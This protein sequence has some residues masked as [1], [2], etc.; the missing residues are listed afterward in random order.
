MKRLSVLVAAAVVSGVALTAP[1]AASAPTTNLVPWVQA[2]D[3]P[4]GCTTTCTDAPPEGPGGELAYDAASH[5]M[6][7]F[8]SGGNSTWVWSG[9]AWSQVADAGDAGCTNDCTHSPPTRNT[10]GM[11]YD[12]VSKAVIVF[13]GNGLNDTWAWNGTSW[14]QIADTGDAGCTTGCSSS[15]PPTLGTQMAFD[16][17]TNQMVMFGGAEPNL[18]NDYNDTWILTYHGGTSYSWSQV[19]DNLDPGCTDTCIASPPTTNVATMTYDVASRQLIV[20]GGEET[21]EEANGQSD[22]WSWTGTTWQQL[23]DDNGNDAG[24]GESSPESLQCPSSPGPRVGAGMAYDPALGQVILFG[25]QT[26]YSSVEYNDTWAWNGTTWTH[27][28][29]AGDPSCVTSCTHSPPPSDT[30]AM[31]DD[32]GSNQL[33]VFGAALYGEG[34]DTWVARAVP[35][36]PSA[37]TKVHATSSKTT[38]TVTWSAP[39][40]L[41]ATPVSKYTVTLTPG[42]KNCTTTGATHCSI[43]G[44][45][46]KDHYTVAV[47]ASNSIGSGPAAQQKNVRG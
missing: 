35:A 18:D 40:Y 13:G 37:P 36:P 17:A 16:N 47:K 44:L 1:V 14:S 11:A 23:D 32:S 20:F 7:L 33:V 8:S 21:A 41:G 29:N 22:T 27:I 45:D 6:L 31:A 19:D 25:G 5:Q 28:D 4:P 24:C 9:S 2:A 34:N 39:V 46:V 10:F 42:N 26:R 3:S 15:P 38:I 12:P 30:F 43:A